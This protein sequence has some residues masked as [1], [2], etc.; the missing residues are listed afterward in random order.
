MVDEA[1]VDVLGGDGARV[2][3]VDERLLGISQKKNKIRFHII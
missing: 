1:L 2:G 3:G